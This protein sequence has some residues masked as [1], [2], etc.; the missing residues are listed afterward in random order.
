MGA[1]LKPQTS[2]LKPVRHEPIAF[3]SES[4]VV[5]EFM[6]PGIE[7]VE[8]ERLSVRDNYRGR[9]SR[10]DPLM[11]PLIGADAMH[12]QPASGYRKG[13]SRCRRTG[14]NRSM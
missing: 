6:R 13:S 5:A 11:L 14:R 3:S 9:K 1:D 10:A 4:T 8:R 7:R 2:N 12:T